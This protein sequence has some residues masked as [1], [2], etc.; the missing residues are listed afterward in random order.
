MNEPTIAI[1]TEAGDIELGTIAEALPQLMEMAAGSLRQ[2]TIDYPAMF[3][4]VQESFT[5]LT[6]S[7]PVEAEENVRAYSAIILFNALAFAQCTM[8]VA[9]DKLG[10]EIHMS[11]QATKIKDLSVN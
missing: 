6:E 4:A 9:A 2:A 1:R 10:L 5:Q 3:T 11:V 7:I 8:E